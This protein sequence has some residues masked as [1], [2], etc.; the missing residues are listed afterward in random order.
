MV[1]AKQPFSCPTAPPSAW[2]C[3]WCL[4]SRLTTTPFLADARQVFVPAF[5]TRRPRNHGQPVGPQASCCRGAINAAS[6]GLLFL[7]PYS[8]DLQFDLA[9]QLQTQGAP[10]QVCR[11]HHPRP[12][13]IITR[14][15]DLYSP[16]D[17]PTTLRA[18]D[19]MHLRGSHSRSGSARPTVP[20]E[21]GCERRA[22]AHSADR[23]SCRRRCRSGSCLQSTAS[24]I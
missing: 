23:N 8:P 4:T 21:L 16:Q 7:L 15:L 14:V 1:V 20:S 2:L 17:I 22:A 5:L 19:T 6:A 18:L 10:A 13:V 11:A 24:G 12:R 9:G 3:R